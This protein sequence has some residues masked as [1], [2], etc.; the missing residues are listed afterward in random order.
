[1]KTNFKATITFAVRYAFQLILLVVVKAFI[2]PFTKAKSPVPADVLTAKQGHLIVANHRGAL[3]PF[4]ICGALPTK[5]ILKILPLAFITYN[6]FYDSPLRPLL[7]ISGCYP[8][9]N[10]KE[11]HKLYGVDG[12]LELIRQGYTICFFPEGTRLRQD[13]GPARPGIIRIH[14]ATPATPFILARIEY[15]KGLRAWLKGERREVSYRHVPRPDY[16]DPEII[17]DDIFKL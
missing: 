4:I 9:R 7:W 5:S 12:T 15:R 11:K 16:S 13:R 6:G 3:D 10:P 8:A 2:N 17:M 1:M 14:T